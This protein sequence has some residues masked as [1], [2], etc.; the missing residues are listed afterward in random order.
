MMKE[1]R[2]RITMITVVLSML[3]AAISGCSKKKPDETPV[4]AETVTTAPDEAG[5]TNDTDASLGEVKVLRWGTHW[6]AGLD[7]NYKD[8]TTGEYTLD[9][10][11]RQASLAALQAAKDQLNVEV[12]FIQ[13]ATDT[14]SELITS[15]LAN[16]PVCDIAILW[17]GSENTVLSQNILQPLDDYEDM[18][19]DSEYSWMLYDK[20]YGHNY[21]LTSKQ[22]FIPRWP[23]IYNATM[24]EKVDSLK[25]ADGNTIYPTTLFKEGNW[26]WS[27]FK[28]YISKI[29]TY[30]A[31]TAAPDACEFK[32]VQAYETDHRFA[33]LSAMFAAGGSIYG[34]DGVK[35]DSAAALK[36]TSF[37]KELMDAGVM[38]DCGLYDDGYTP[39]WCQGAS[40]FQN[41]GTVFTDCPD[42]WIGGTS[43]AAAERG[44]SV[45]IIPW[46]RPDDMS[47]DD[48]NYR[49]VLTVGDSIGILK[50]VDAE[51]TKL[52]L[53]FLKVY[54]STYY[55][56]L[57]G[58]DSISAYKDSAATDQAAGFGFDIFNE[59]YGDDLLS[60]FQYVA[61]QAIPNDYSDLLGYRGIWDDIFGKSL[62][63][64]DGYASYEVSIA[65]NKNLFTDL[66][67]K[68]ETILS[69]DEIRDN[70][71]PN[72]SVTDPLVFPAGTDP[73][74][75]A[76]SDYIS[77]VD[78]VDGTLDAT[79]AAY[80][81]SATDFTKVGSY[82]DG[83]KVKEADKSGNEASM[84]ATIVIYNPDNK[85]APTVT[86][87]DGYRTIKMD[88]DAS[89]IAW[90][91]DFIASAV[92]ADGLDVSA[93]ITA[94]ISSL[95]TSTPDEYDVV[96]TVTDFAGNSSNV[97]LKVTVAAA[98]E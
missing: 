95:D 98:D 14:R 94:D 13:Y 39:K 77:I 18:F 30:Y 89:A 6:V 15:V 35:A 58:V 42:W 44:E 72:I 80:D 9:E 85:T 31:N 51:T 56:T 38:T 12:E 97:T 91:G 86:P 48:P 59:K 19:S 3:I 7:P 63:G 4:G 88:E 69:S 5:D 62:Y 49:Q 1:K 57:G 21:F 11:T 45:G 29:K 78:A 55:K 8:P 68:M 41:G 67:S 71:A 2:M 66:A 64:I 20:M 90:K 16:N 50:G 93:N 73:S 46:P 27:T 43:S 52:A 26:T 23:L 87:V 79:A 28:D 10:A 24:I 60:A 25:D 54:Y 53:E 65:A 83:L 32:T 33:G 61:N 76:F 40:D 82:S 92:D 96:I 34:A 22:A 70:I 74:T 37:I 75:I 84:N 17:G 47:A 81:Y 36:G